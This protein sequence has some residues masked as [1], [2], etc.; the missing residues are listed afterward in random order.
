MEGMP[1]HTE[2]SQ[3][4]KTSGSREPD[5]TLH[6]T[7]R[8]GEIAIVGPGAHAREEFIRTVSDEIPLLTEDM[9]FG[10]LQIN[11]QLMLHL[12]GVDYSD[13]MPFSWDLISNKLLGYIVLFPWEQPDTYPSVLQMV[14]TL[15][16]RYRIPIVIAANLSDNLNVMPA[17]VLK[18]SFNLSDCGEFTFCTASEASSARHVLAVLID[19]VIEKLN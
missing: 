3:T 15:T 13:Q 9:V 1:N 18:A 6:H 4:S 14:D 17:Q 19:A 10:R 7:M 5:S 11:K 12:Y 8:I 16:S 2:S